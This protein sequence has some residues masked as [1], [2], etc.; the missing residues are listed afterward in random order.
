VAAGAA[1]GTNMLEPLTQN[2]VKPPVKVI[3]KSSVASS[4]TLVLAVIVTIC[5]WYLQAVQGD[6]QARMARWTYSYFL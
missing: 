2:A 5:Y 4:D 1:V 6:L 3:Q